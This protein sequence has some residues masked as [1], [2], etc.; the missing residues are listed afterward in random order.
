MIEPDYNAGYPREYIQVM[1]VSIYS[2]YWGEYVVLSGK[3][4]MDACSQM[5]KSDRPPTNT[6]QTAVDMMLAGF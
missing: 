3:S 6:E 2:K 1:N 5:V 4:L